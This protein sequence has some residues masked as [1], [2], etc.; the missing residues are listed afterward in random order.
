MH[1]LPEKQTDLWDSS[2]HNLGAN[3][4]S[5]ILLELHLIFPQQLVV[6]A[7]QEPLPAKQFL[8][9]FVPRTPCQHAQWDLMQGNKVVTKNQKHIAPVLI[10]NAVN[11]KFVIKQLETVGL[12][13]LELLQ[14]KPRGIVVLFAATDL[15]PRLKGKVVVLVKL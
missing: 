1:A 10:L 11:V 4:I 3:L 6:H 12:G 5:I 15:E 9:I 7:L 14:I 13:L 2:S 8:G